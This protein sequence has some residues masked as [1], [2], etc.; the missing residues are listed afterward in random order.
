VHGI[1]GVDFLKPGVCPVWPGQPAT[2]HWDVPEPAAH[3]TAE[4][5]R[6]AFRDPFLILDRNISLFLSLPLASLDRLAIKREID[7]IGRQ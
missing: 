2:A 1:I 3:G 5:L 4:E 6:G 7:R